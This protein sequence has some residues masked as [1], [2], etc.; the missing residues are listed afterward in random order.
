MAVALQ[1][2]ELEANYG[3]G[4][5]VVPGLG[6]GSGLGA[7]GGHQGSFLVSITIRASYRSVIVLTSARGE[8]ERE[9]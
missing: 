9:A 3:R 8:L 5:M 7:S 2:G 4:P 1:L 6:V